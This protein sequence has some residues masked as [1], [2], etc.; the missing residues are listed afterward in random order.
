M[1]DKEKDEEGNKE[2]LSTTKESAA[3]YAAREPLHGVPLCGGFTFPRSC[4]L[5][6]IYKF[7]HTIFMESLEYRLFL[8]LDIF[9]PDRRFWSRKLRWWTTFKGRNR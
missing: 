7:L 9:I 8:L 6:L 5:T 4:S 3:F 2:L 1:G